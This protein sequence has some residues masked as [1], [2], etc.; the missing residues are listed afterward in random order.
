MSKKDKEQ[1]ETK[2]NELF[3]AIDGL[4]PVDPKSLHQFEEAM[5]KDVIPKIVDAVED[6]RLR[7]A[8]SRRWQ[9]KY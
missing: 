7:A 4:H 1:G 8:E 5:N 6:R 9:L 3:D 2:K